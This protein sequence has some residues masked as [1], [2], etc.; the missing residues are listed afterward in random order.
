MQL[1]TAFYLESTCMVHFHGNDKP[2]NI[3]W[4]NVYF[5]NHTQYL[6][7]K[8]YHIFARDTSTTHVLASYTTA[9]DIFISAPWESWSSPIQQRMTS[10]INNLLV[11]HCFLITIVLKGMER[12]P[13]LQQWGGSKK[14]EGNSF[15]FVGKL[16]H[17]AR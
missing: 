14:I 16:L 17:C 3:D 4:M 15:K 2:C 9:A 1:A 7:H 8:A 6:Y 10:D 11:S 12:A 13:N 5:L